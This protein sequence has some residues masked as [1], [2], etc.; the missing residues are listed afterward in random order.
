MVAAVEPGDFRMSIDLHWMMSTM[1]ARK[2]AYG[3]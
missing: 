2:K 3:L 1:A